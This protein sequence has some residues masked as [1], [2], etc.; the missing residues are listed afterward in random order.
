RLHGRDELE[1]ALQEQMTG[2]GKTNPIDREA[3]RDALSQLRP[4][5]NPAAETRYPALAEAFRR[6]LR[7]D[8]INKDDDRY[9]AYY[10][11]RTPIAAPQREAI[12]AAGT[13]FEPGLCEAVAEAFPAERQ[14]MVAGLAADQP[15]AR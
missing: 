9:P 4:N 2:L 1:I 15:E 8:A 14:A 11:A 5:A 12:F 13:Y 7:A 3:L 10:L 6:R